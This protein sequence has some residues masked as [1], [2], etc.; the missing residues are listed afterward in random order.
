VRVKRWMPWMIAALAAIGLSV[1]AVGNAGSNHPQKASA[2]KLKVGL[3]TD[4]GGLN[5]RGFNQSSYAG[6][7]RAIRKLG[8]QGTVLTSSSQA[9]YIPNFTSLIRKKYDL[10]IGVGF[11]QESAIDTIATKYPNLKFA[12]VDIPIGDLKHKPKNFQGIVFKENEVGCLAGDLA[13][14]VAAAN[15]TP[16]KAGA[17]GPTI[18]WVGGIPVPAVIRYGAGYTF[19]AKKAVPGITVLKD[20]SQDFVAQDK[21][22]ELALKHFDAGSSVEFQVAGGCGLGVLDAA[23]EQGKWGIGVDVDQR[24]T[25]P[26]NVLTSA[27]KK[28]DVG[29]YDTI[30]AAVKGTFKGGTDRLFTLRDGGVGL[31]PISSKVPA[32]IRA[33]EKKTEAAILSGK[34]KP[35]VK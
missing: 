34:L 13:A 29:V 2:T 6:L 7:K 12:G 4:I 8:V 27:E 17:S 14:R 15:I 30:A 26:Q 35:P 3:V 28:V 24:L 20:F 9:D 1:A 21:C 5:D 32:S 19:C 18:G 11:L 33:A 22:K 23:K 10:I 31:A 16:S 25:A